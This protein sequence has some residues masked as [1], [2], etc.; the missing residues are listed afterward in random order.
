MLKTGRIFQNPRNNHC[1][2]SN[3]TTHS[4]PILAGAIGNCIEVYDY[5][6]YI[7]F[8][9]IIAA[10]F[11]PPGDMA[12]AF[13]FW[14]YALER[15][16][17]PTA[18]I[19]ISRYVD[20]HGRS[21][22][23]FLSVIGMIAVGLLMCLLPTY[24]A[25]GWAAPVLLLIVRVMQG[26]MVSSEYVTAMVYIYEHAPESKKGVMGSVTFVSG[27]IGSLIA[28]CLSFVIIHNSSHDFLVTWGWKIPYLFSVIML[29]ASYQLRK[30]MLETPAFLTLHSP[31][32]TFKQVISTNHTNVIYAFILTAIT[33]AI[34]SIFIVFMPSHLITMKHFS[35]SLTTAL[36][37]IN[38]AFYAIMLLVMG[39]LSDHAGWENVILSGLAGILLF[40]YPAYYLLNYTSS[41]LILEIVLLT[42][43][44]II[45]A[46]NGPLCAYLNSLFPASA[47]ATSL[48]ISYGI[49]LSLFGGVTPLLCIYLTKITGNS[50]SPAL[51]LIALAVLTIFVMYFRTARIENKSPM[52]S[53]G[54]TTL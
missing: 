2:P 30:N 53:S 25:I 29:L 14:I 21:K 6:I 43:M 12:I 15:F 9:P 46:L 44:I 17:R 5:S 28:S 52:E 3:I 49:S 51:Y 20:Q 11:F 45:A 33:A 19:F 39:K 4:K 35:M 22:T 31:A 16:F 24:R 7:F 26:I 18:A 50:N 37:S 32:P 23:L 54:S 38:L 48:A 13:T 1:M 47:R 27:I 8:A 41:T 34:Y 36:T 42:Y 10:A 40:T